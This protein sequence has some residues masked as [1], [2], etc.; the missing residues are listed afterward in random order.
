MS[1]SSPHPEVIRDPDPP[2]EADDTSTSLAFS[3]DPSSRATTTTSN[4]GLVVD[5][6]MS[7]F[8]SAQ[9]PVKKNPSGSNSRQRARN[10]TNQ[11]ELLKQQI[12]LDFQHIASSINQSPDENL[13]ALDA[14]SAH[15]RAQYTKLQLL[16]TRLARGKLIVDKEPWDGRKALTTLKEAMDDEQEWLK[17]PIAME[18]SCQAARQKENA[19]SS[20]V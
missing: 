5:S 10:T 17:I 3:F 2:L 7:R 19:K 8:L 12:G 18:F 4:P 9:F 1:P 16:Q 20:E 13:I 14:L 6:P 15:A 11:M